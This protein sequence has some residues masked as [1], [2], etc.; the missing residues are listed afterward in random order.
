MNIAVSVL[1]CS[2]CACLVGGCKKDAS[3]SSSGREEP[4]L[5]ING[6]TSMQTFAEF[7]DKHLTNGVSWKVVEDNHASAPPKLPF[8]MLVIVVS[9][10]IHHGFTG[11]LRV[12][13]INDQ[14]WQT[15][16]N[17]LLYKA[18]KDFLMNFSGLQ[19]NAE[20]KAELPPFTEIYLRYGHARWID[21]RL[22]EARSERLREYG[23]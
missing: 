20:G 21:K 9:N 5:L 3:R 4:A 23:H 13:F 8:H 12:E 10:Y 22:S 17:P 19:F 14:L 2:I 18:Y 1:V 15:W 6:I 11:E 7:K 16:F